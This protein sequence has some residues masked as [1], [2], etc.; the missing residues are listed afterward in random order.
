MHIQ[1]SLTQRVFWGLGG[2]FYYYLSFWDCFSLLV[3][4]CFGNLQRIVEDSGWGQ[5]K[6]EKNPQGRF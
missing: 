3:T 2:V 1:W 6:N 4:L 5:V